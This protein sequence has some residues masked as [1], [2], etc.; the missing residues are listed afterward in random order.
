LIR[1]QEGKG[2]FHLL[3]VGN[4]GGQGILG[5]LLRAGV[6]A[7]RSC[8]VIGSSI[9]GS[10]DHRKKIEVDLVKVN[11]KARRGPIGDPRTYD[12]ML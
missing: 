9:L 2:L 12:R 6:L 1:G 7:V 5:I 11:M 8:D 3:K 10:G 4:L